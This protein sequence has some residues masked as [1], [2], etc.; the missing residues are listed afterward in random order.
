MENAIKQKI[1]EIAEC[2]RSKVIREGVNS[3][4]LY[5]GDSGVLLFMFYYSIFS[6][7][8]KYLLL[9]EKMAENIL[10]MIVTREEQY[11]FCSGL[12]GELYLFDF[13]R[14]ARIVDIDISIFQSKLEEYLLL[15][16]RQNTQLNK[17]DF[18][19][20][21]LGIGLYF[22]KHKTNNTEILELVNYLYN[23]AEIDN[24]SNTFKWNSIIDYEK[25]N[26]GYNLSMSHGI[27]S[28]IIF[29]LRTLNSGIF[30]V[31]INRMLTGA[32][33]YIFSQQKD[34]SQF[35]SFF[36]NYIPLDQQELT[37]KSRLAWCYG[38][39]GIGVAL[40][41]AGKILED[42]NLKNKGLDILLQSTN[43]K[44]IKENF[45]IDP[46]ICHGTIGVAMIYRRMFID[47]RLKEFEMA[48]LYWLNQ[49]LKMANFKD[50]LAGFKSLIHNEWKCDYSLLT[51][52]S[53]IGLVLISYMDNNTQNWD[54][55]FLLS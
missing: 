31:K 22:L 51:G 3:F 8:K 50:G 54:E 26:L 43:R 45:I 42:I 7:R 39:L 17:Y 18:M 47:T 4:G 20:G 33:N 21:A 2:I 12:A 32:V 28:I 35:G 52:I 36:P 1:D 23:T 53:G 5:N 37:T 38:D 49:T 46:G 24:N 15:R 6:K 30:D 40:W 55:L 16:M 29:L 25:N 13:L 11:S 14:E 27:S 9:S 41:Q 34:L 19:H 48:N 44:K 10:E